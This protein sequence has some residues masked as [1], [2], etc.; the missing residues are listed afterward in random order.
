LLVSTKEIKT[1][2]EVEEFLQVVQL[3]L[4][5]TP[6]NLYIVRRSRN[7]DKT[8]KFMVEY[9][10]THDYICEKLLEL[11]AS[12]YSFTDRDYD[13]TRPGDV[14]IFGQMFIEK[15]TSVS[16]EV[17]IK[18]KLNQRLVCLSFHPKEF[19]LKYPYN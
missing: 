17:Y 15:D 13:V 5:E 19:D 10:I 6:E 8:F 7:E 11:D 18:L 12:N 9:G 14:W 4:K 2:K 3:R 1:K 16:W